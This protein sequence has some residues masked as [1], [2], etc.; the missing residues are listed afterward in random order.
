GHAEGLIHR[1]QEIS[2]AQDAALRAQRLLECPPKH[3]SNVFDG[4]VLVD[5]EIA[6]YF[7]VEIKA[8]M[9]SKQLQHVVEETNARRDAVPATAV[10]AQRQANVG[11]L[12]PAMHGRFPHTALACA[13][14]SSST[15]SPRA[16]TNRSVWS[17]VPIV[18]R[19]QPAQP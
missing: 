19:T 1:H 18:M 10:N 4:M 17:A 3:D 12:R 7:Q 14:P 16:R 8:A 6:V 13:I 11:L 2:R 5:I 9:V 15:T